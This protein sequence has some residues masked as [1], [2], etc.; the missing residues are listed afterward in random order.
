ME[1]PVGPQKSPVHVEINALN[2]LEKNHGPILDSFVAGGSKEKGH[3]DAAVRVLEASSGS[4][5]VTNPW[6]SVIVDEPC[7][8]NWMQSPVVTTEDAG[9]WNVFGDEEMAK[10]RQVQY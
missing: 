1:T 4:H 2:A 6:Q 5:V 3:S 8:A 10:S 9:G 7:S